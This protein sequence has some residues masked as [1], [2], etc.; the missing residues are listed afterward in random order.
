M[1]SFNIIL[2]FTMLLVLACPAR[3]GHFCH[4]C[5]CQRH[6]KKICRL[7]CEK[8]KETKIEYGCECEDFC[9][10]GHSKK[11]GVKVECDC[12]GHRHR[13]IVWQPVCAKVHTRKKLVKKEITK[14]VPSYKWVVEEYCCICGQCV[15]IEDK[16]KDKDKDKA[17]PAKEKKAE[18]LPA[19][20]AGDEP[21]E[22]RASDEPTGDYHAYFLDAEADSPHQAA[23][24]SGMPDDEESDQANVASMDGRI[25]SDKHGIEASDEPRRL[26]LGLLRR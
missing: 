23:E 11:C 26:F 21:S 20:L 14:E 4:R 3:A 15:K 10:P 25:V 9:I 16:D 7:V 2:A 12:H 22:I 13:E 1:R 18:R 17:K 8:K 19:P 5:G 6:C 24:P